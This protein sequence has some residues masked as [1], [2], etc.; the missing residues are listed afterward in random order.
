MWRISAFWVLVALAALSWAAWGVVVH[1]ISPLYDESFAF[2]VFYLSIFFTFSFS[3]GVVFSLIWK[4][5]L[6]TQACYVCL[7]NGVR[8]G[9]FTAIAGTG[10]LF[11][12]QM[13]RVTWKEILLLILLS[14]LLEAFFIEK[15]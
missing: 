10:F 3:F 4:I 5:F 6:P 8:E 11:F 9:F 15:K 7:K 12:L 2:L 13:G 1:K 14:F